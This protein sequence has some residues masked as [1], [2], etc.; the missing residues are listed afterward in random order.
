[1]SDDIED[2]ISIFIVEDHEVTRLGLR[3]ILEE[4]PGVKIVGE[5]ADGSSALEQIL[6]LKP[7]LVLMDIGLPAVD[8]ISVTRGIKA[9][10]NNTRVLM[11]TSHDADQDL[12]AS[13]EA[14]ADGYCL[15]DAP[16]E[17]LAVA[18][19]SAAAGVGW[20]DP[21]IAGR[22]LSALSAIG[23]GGKTVRAVPEDPLSLSRR[24]QE[25]LGLLVE[26]LSNQEIA[27]RL[28]LGL[29]TVKTHIRHLLNK[30][31]ASDRTQAA[32]RAVKLGYG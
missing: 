21:A 26:G 25:V 27:D 8:G 24:E 20:F 3:I 31:G 10:L 11:L 32:V 19:K 9:A 5:A 17:R 12:F 2:S 28:S 7:R 4:M 13:M 6:A 22:A 16:I 14:G 29:E 15:K 23:S 1:M 30:L 18:I